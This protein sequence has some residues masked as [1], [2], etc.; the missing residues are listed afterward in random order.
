M[1]ALKVPRG[2]SVATIQEQQIYF[3]HQAA[4]MNYQD[5]AQRQRQLAVER[6]SRPAAGSK[7]DSND[8]DNFGPGQALEIWPR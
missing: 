6:W 4:R 7:T 1:A 3:A 2:Q 8:A 5:I